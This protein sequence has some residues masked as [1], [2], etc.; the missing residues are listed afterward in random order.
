MCVTRYLYIDLVFF[1][2]FFS[3]L[4]CVFC[5]F[6]DKLVRFWVFLELCGL[7]IIPIFFY[8][9][10]D[11]IGGFYNSLLIYIVV[12]RLSSI[13]IISGMIFSTFYYFIF[14]GFVMKFGLFPFRV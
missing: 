2:F 11:I 4:F 8:G 12:C 14:W 10:K 9:S 6:V 7:S 1:S 5:R 3:I 13:F